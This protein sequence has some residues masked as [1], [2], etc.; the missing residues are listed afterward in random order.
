MTTFLNHQADIFGAIEMPI[1]RIS[2][3][4]TDTGPIRGF[5]TPGKTYTATPLNDAL[6]AFNIVND[7][8]YQEVVTDSRF[9]IIR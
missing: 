3:L 2:L 1:Q 5:L 7:K 4:C 8:G 6:T 9:Q